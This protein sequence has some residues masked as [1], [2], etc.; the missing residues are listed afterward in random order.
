MLILERFREQA[1]KNPEHAALTFKEKTFTYRE[2]DEITDR[3]AA[4]LQRR[5]I[6][7][8][9]VVSVLI[10][11]CE[12]IAI[13]PLGILKAGAAYQPMD[14]G[15]PI[16]R[17]QYMAKDAGSS[18]I[19]VARDL[20][21]LTEG[22]SAERMDMEDIEGLPEADG[23]EVPEILPEDLFVILYTS[24]STGEPKGCMLDHRNL[25]SFADWYVPYYGADASC[26]MATHAS[27]VFD[28]SMME[29][30]MPLTAGA[31]V[32]IVPEEIRTDLAKLNEFFEKN[33]I[34]HTSQK[35]H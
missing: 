13:A 26:R 5:G 25:A 21:G 29:L 11:R 27:F 6:G 28:V 12:H 9:D 3:L 23:F 2:L 4:E 30:Y 33:G 20:A 14:P 18:L 34:T 15:Y 31:A 1:E 7:K 16:R 24:G 8:G 10:P 22:I 19:I 17:I 32:Y 35:I